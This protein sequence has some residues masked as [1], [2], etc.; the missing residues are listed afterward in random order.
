MILL[1]SASPSYPSL[2]RR[3]AA[4]I[5]DSLLLVPVSMAYGLLYIGIAKFIFQQSGDRADGILFQ[6]GWSVALFAYFAYFWMRGGQ[7]TGMK[8]WRIKIASTQ[9][10]TPTLRACLLRFLVAPVGWLCFFTAFF[11][12]QRLC[13]HDQFSHTHLLIINRDD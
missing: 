6:I 5:Y 4:I 9:N 11:N 13:L 7:T 3:L 12:R 10:S 1:F 2:L 8:A